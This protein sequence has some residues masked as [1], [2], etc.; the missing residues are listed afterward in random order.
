MSNQPKEKYLKGNKLKNLKLTT[1]M[2][3]MITISLIGLVTVFL[4]G[5]FSMNEAKSGQGILYND[6]FQHQTNVLEVKSNF[7]NMRANYTK[8]LDN[9]EYTDKQYDQVQ[10][11]KQSVTDGLNE[12]SAR[13]LD[14]KEKE[15]F[16]DVEAKMDTYYKDIEQIMDVKKKSGTYDSDE[17][18][19]INKSSTAIVETISLLSTYN[20]EES[21]KLYANTQEVI[22]QRALILGSVLLL[23]L[24]TLIIISYVMI[25]SIRQRMKAITRY[26]EEVT[27]GNLTATIDPYLTEGNNEI[28]VIARA[29]SK[30]TDSTSNV[31]RGVIQ[32]SHHINQVSDLTNQNMTGLNERIR[33]VSATVEELSAAMEEASAHTENMNH[34]ANEMQQGAEYISEQTSKQAEAAY[35]TSTKAEKLKHEARESSQAAI[36]MYDHTSKKMSEA[37][38]RA[39]AV[40]QIG[41]LSQ[42]ILDVTAQ[43]NLLALNA[44][45]E[46][47]RAGEAGR[48]FAVVASEIRKLADDSRQAADQIQQVTEEVT[49][50]V[51]NLSSNAKELLS[52]MFNQVGKD[53]KLLENTAEQYYIDSLEHANAVKDLNA[54][55][56]QV[57]ANI[58]TLVGS[59]HEIASASEQSA[60][61]SQEIA[62]HMIASTA[63]SVEVV[64]QSDQVKESALNLDKLVQEFKV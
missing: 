37:L 35:V 5:M 29:I 24:G 55:S 57:T 56:Q 22:K 61:S 36:D 15:I 59:I 13:T 52:F 16:A 63:Q 23:S 26:C 34:S 51:T 64:Q 50:S 6:R 12:F 42:S 20:E 18:G 38:E 25:R 2:V 28:S 48:G 39:T 45:I 9:A 41:I 44:S 11:G 14:T 3:I 1:T 4:I 10:K 31:I 7:Y 46:A 32:E 33:E 43:T 49:Q 60:A 40:D 30:M 8:V 19:R 53:Y 54:T 17:R 62:G 47:A 21:A 58:K 27:Q